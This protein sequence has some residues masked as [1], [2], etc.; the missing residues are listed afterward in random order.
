MPFISAFEKQRL[1][2]FCEVEA[3]LVSKVS[4]GSVT[5]KHGLEKTKQNKTTKPKTTQN[6]KK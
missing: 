4:L 2:D 3:S 5:Q 6:K 1:E